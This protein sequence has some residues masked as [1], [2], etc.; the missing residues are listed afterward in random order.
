[1]MKERLG[2]KLVEKI[3]EGS[4]LPAHRERAM[5]PCEFCRGIIGVGVEFYSVEMEDGSRAAAHRTCLEADAAA[6]SRPL[7]D[8]AKAMS[9]IGKDG[10][11]P[12]PA[13]ALTRCTTCGKGVSVF[14]LC[15][16]D[17]GAW[18][19][20]CFEGTPCGKGQHG[21]G[22]RTVILPV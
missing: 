20:E 1:M 16:E 10:V 7:T 17:N 5:L 21:E 9:H 19:L 14:A 15:D 13:E 18:C 11:V 4:A 12:A 3:P 2:K 6:R 8:E 22:C